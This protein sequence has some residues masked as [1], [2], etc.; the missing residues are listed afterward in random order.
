[1]ALTFATATLVFAILLT[2]AYLLGLLLSGKTEKKEAKLSG[3]PAGLLTFS[4]YSLSIAGLILTLATDFR[5]TLP[6]FALLALVLL[7]NILSLA[8]GGRRCVLASLVLWHLTLLLGKIPEVDV[9]VGE[10]TG[11]VREMSLNDHWSF[12]WAH[13]PSYN[14][15]PTIA[16]IQATLSR[17]TSVPWYSYRLGTALFIAWALAYD[18]ALYTLALRVFK[19]E[20]AALLTI[21]LLA[22]T[23]ETAIHQHP[24]QWSGNGLVILATSTLFKPEKRREDLALLALLYAGALLAHATGL[25]FL[26]MTLCIPLCSALSK[27]AT[28]L[29]VTVTNEKM[30]LSTMLVAA[31]LIVTLYRSVYTAGYAGYVMPS[32]LSV[33][34][35]FI[36]LL[37]RFFLPTEEIGEV[38]HIPLYE[39]A[40][41][42]P[43]QGY[44]WTY[45]LALASAY[46]LHSFIRR[47]V[48][49]YAFTL[50][51]PA[52]LISAVVFLGYGL[53]HVKGL[54]WLNRTT[55]VF[56]P[57]S[58]PIA[59]KVL[60]E[61][62]GKV[63]EHR[64]LSKAFLITLLGLFLITGPIAAQD[65]NISPIQYAKM[66][67]S[68]IV[69]INLGDVVE[70]TFIIRASER[71][72]QATY[73]VYSY[74]TYKT[75][76]YRL[77]ANP[78]EKAIGIWYPVLTTRL[79]SAVELCS[80]L[81]K[82]QPPNME[83]STLSEQRS[84]DLYMNLVYN[85]LRN[86]VYM[87]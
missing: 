8:K 63:N 58:I 41:V 57:F 6:Y 13:N 62:I 9:R 87:R 39:R 21:P 33:Y 68:E 27:I 38:Q 73:Y 7:L 45:S 40:G 22:V 77:S 46:M 48:D 66:R 34:Q 32:I 83:V 26:V 31:L 80:F 50:Y 35:G 12:E 76:A 5:E 61:I 42:P 36:D 17:V 43:I 37:R 86:L 67:Q 53:L 44:V 30:R 79:K 28:R 47:R 81:N 64:F 52:I 54:Y 74:V 51:L 2:I 78:E 29:K 84:A 24:Y 25:A 4:L 10:V 82:L 65:P 49:F 56:I 11:M 60:T 19:D 18:L 1:M 85:S 14:P 55:Y 3:A 15:L 59:A 69:P 16:F 72:T 75:G 20:R 70:A 71:S 23:P